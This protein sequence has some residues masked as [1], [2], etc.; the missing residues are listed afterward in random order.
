EVLGGAIAVN[1]SFFDLG[2]MDPET[3]RAKLN[4]EISGLDIGK[5][6]FVK[7]EKGEDTRIF[8]N[9]RL[10]AKG[11]DFKKLA[12]FENPGDISGSFNITHIGSEV[13]YRLLAAM[14]PNGKDGNVGYVKEQLYKGAKPELLILELKYGQLISRMWLDVGSL[15]GLGFIRYPSPPNPIEFKDI[16][17]DEIMQNFKRSKQ[18]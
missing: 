2:N 11:I 15:F 16:S 8:A 9:I 14:D 18:G 1:N 4:V 13:A 5:L 6:K 7:V 10:N 17:I 12:K 3:I